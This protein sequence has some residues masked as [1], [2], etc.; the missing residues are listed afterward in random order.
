M[1]YVCGGEGARAT[2]GAVEEGFGI[3]RRFRE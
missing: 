2:G 3:S 1:G